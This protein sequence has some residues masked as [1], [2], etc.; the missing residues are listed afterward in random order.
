MKRSTL[1]MLVGVLLA[2]SAVPA[3]GS[4]GL[5]G[6]WHRDNYGNSHEV[7]ICNGSEGLVRCQYLQVPEP[8]LGILPTTSDTTRGVFRGNLVSVDDCPDYMTDA[9]ADAVVIAQGTAVYTSGIST[10]QTIAV[11][12]DGSMT[13]SW[14]TPG[15]F[16]SPFVCPWYD[17]YDRALSESPDCEFLGN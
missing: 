1:A 9:C 8:S 2:L 12:A 7:L 6:R 17:S 14:D 16:G 3:L 15:N 13:Y 10:D 4:S 11:H 5:E